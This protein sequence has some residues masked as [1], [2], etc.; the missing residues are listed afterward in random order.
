MGG[1][2]VGIQG[3]PNQHCGHM[4]ILRDC[5]V[6]LE[7]TGRSM[8]T[9]HSPQH[10]QQT[11]TMQPRCNRAHSSIQLPFSSSFLLS[12]METMMLTGPAVS[13][14]GSDNWH[15]PLLMSQVTSPTQLS[16]ATQ[17][18]RPKTGFC[19]IFFCIGECYR[20]SYRPYHRCR[21]AIKF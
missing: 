18:Y 13:E 6:P 3:I 16:T 19:G 12:M 15:H 7:I 5:V 11:G 1:T 2:I 9:I 4:D 17:Q 10:A 21:I 8:C 20:Q 14:G